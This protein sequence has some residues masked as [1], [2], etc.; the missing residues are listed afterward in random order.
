M[1]RVKDLS[2]LKNKVN[3]VQ[4]IIQTLREQATVRVD[5]HPV[6]EYKPKLMARFNSPDLIT[7]DINASTIN[8]L[9]ECGYRAMRIDK[10]GASPVIVFTQHPIKKG[11]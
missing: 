3:Q 11:V 10:Y 6:D 1:T 5:D 9:F 2:D 4:R 7:F 8:R